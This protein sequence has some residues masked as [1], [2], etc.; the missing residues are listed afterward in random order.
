MQAL[1]LITCYQNTVLYCLYSFV[2]FKLMVSRKQLW[3]LGQSVRFSPCTA[4]TVCV[5]AS[6]ACMGRSGHLM[7][8]LIVF[9]PFPITF[10]CSDLVV[11]V[12]LINRKI[13]K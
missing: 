8:R 3:K 13:A 2:P 1:H 6:I 7:T 5:Y 12:K 4:C 10:F 11:R 9:F